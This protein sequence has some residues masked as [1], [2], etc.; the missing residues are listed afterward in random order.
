MIQVW[1]FL[2]IIYDTHDGIEEH[3]MALGDFMERIKSKWVERT[4][5]TRASKPFSIK[6]S[7]V[8]PIIAPQLSGNVIWNTELRKKSSYIDGAKKKNVKGNYTCM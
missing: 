4:T 1:I 8:P 5:F 6:S 7:M 2:Q 3:P